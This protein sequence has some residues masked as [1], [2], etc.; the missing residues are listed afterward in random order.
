MTGP[1]LTT[2]PDGER[3]FMRVKEWV[4]GGMVKP[5]E[6]AFTQGLERN[7]ARIV[8]YACGKQKC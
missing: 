1:Y 3:A 8:V 5:P 6:L 7:M 4:D 2:D